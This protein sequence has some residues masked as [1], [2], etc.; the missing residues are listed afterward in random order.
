MRWVGTSQ[1]C[2]EERQKPVA[3]L[4]STYGSVEE[5]FKQ[6][7]GVWSWKKVII[8]FIFILFFFLFLNGEENLCYG[9]I[10]SCRPSFPLP[11]C[12]PMFH[13]FYG[14]KMSKTT[15]TFRFWLTY[16]TARTHTL[17]EMLLSPVLNTHHYKHRRPELVRASGRQ[18]R[19][20]AGFRFTVPL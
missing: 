14:T 16:K 18:S 12:C 3:W 11:T 4:M 5:M 1:M 15:I 17:I 10:S 8:S 19:Y 6:L 2:L 13:W 20:I 9:Q 7:V